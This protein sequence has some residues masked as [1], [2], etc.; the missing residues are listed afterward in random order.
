MQWLCFF[1]SFLAAKNCI[2][3]QILGENVASFKWSFTVFTPAVEFK[4]F[5]K[6]K[7]DGSKNK[8]P[9]PLDFL[10]VLI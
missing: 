3:S 5:L 8:A 7:C 4:L 6:P 1:I 9:I 2:S 10:S